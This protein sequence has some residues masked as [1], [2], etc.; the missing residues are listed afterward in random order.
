MNETHPTCDT[1]V[2]F[3]TGPLQV[4]YC[5]QF[6]RFASHWR[7]LSSSH[8]YLGYLGAILAPSWPI[9]VHPG[10]ILADLGA[11]LAYV[12]PSW[13]HLRAIPRSSWGHFT[14]TDMLHLACGSLRPPCTLSVC[15]EALDPVRAPLSFAKTCFILC[16]F[17][18]V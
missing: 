16:L 11:I 5:R 14:F 7:H 13:G 4:L 8:R 17:G 9:L 6:S 1:V 15:F 18:F 12:G 2:I 10:A 3:R